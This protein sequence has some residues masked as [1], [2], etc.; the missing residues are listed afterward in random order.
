MKLFGPIYD[1]T[2]RCARH[3]LAP[4]Y[5]T[6]MSFSEAVF[7]PIPPDVMLIP[8]ALA[9]TRRAWWY[10]GLATLGSAIGGVVGYLLGAW[11][12]DPVVQPLIESLGYQMAFS[13]V[14]DWFQVYG[15][16]I[17]FVAGFSPI[18]YKVFT[19]SAGMLQMMFMPFLIASIVGRGLRFVLV[20][21][22]MVL[23]GEKMEAKLRSYIE[24]IG[25]AVIVLAVILY[26][27]FR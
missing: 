9:K 12:F 1:W 27:I 3:R 4:F 15:V 6:L 26:I 8:M 7:F 21:G 10:A 24:I 19:L 25:W 16:W 22:L 2:M 23:G 5:L 11:L 20:A 18:P 14:V 13:K 17:V